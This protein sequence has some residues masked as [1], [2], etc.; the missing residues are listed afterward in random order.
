MLILRLLFIY[1]L[2]CLTTLEYVVAQSNFNHTPTANFNIRGKI[3]KLN[4]LLEE[5]KQDIESGK[6]CLPQ[7]NRNKVL[8]CTGMEISLSSISRLS[9]PKIEPCVRKIE[10]KSYRF[11]REGEEKKKRINSK[12]WL[13]FYESTK[14]A[15]TLH[16]E[17]LVFMKKR[18]GHVECLHELLHVI[19][20]T[21]K[22]KH[23]LSPAQRKIKYHKVESLLLRL[24]DAVAELE[25]KK[26]IASAKRLARF[27]EYGNNIS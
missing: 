18:G 25:K 9:G 4:R 21:Q 2:F 3:T 24:S 1:P 6:K 26:E 15:E 12:L 7:F 27:I 19:Q 10:K 20:W 22:T 8:F 11:V 5:I 14:W 13:S 23:H 17:K 16:E